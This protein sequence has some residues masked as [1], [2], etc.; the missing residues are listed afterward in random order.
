[1]KILVLS[2]DYIDKDT[3]IQLKNNYFLDI[4]SLKTIL[5]DLYP[6]LFEKDEND[7]K[8]FNV[9]SLDEFIDKCNNQEIELMDWWVTNIEM[10]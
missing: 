8:V 9:Y 3:V 5:N 6:D 7:S 1:M 4:K 2:V 10:D